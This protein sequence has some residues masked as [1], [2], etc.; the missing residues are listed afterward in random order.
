[1]KHVVVSNIQIGKN[2][3]EVH[4]LWLKIDIVSIFIFAKSHKI[5]TPKNVYRH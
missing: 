1:M 4:I 3:V 2:T 5:I